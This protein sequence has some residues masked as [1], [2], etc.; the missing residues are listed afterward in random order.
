VAWCSE[1][2]TR[3]VAAFTIIEVAAAMAVV[4]IASGIAIAGMQEMIAAEKA[5]AE[6]VRLA[7]DIRRHRARAMQEG[8]HSLVR[9]E[10][11]RGG[12]VRLIYGAKR[13]GDVGG[14]TPCELMEAGQHDSEVA[15]HY[16]FIEAEME[17]YAVIGG[18]TD[19]GNA[20]AARQVCFTSKGEPRSS[21]LLTEKPVGIE[22]HR[23]GKTALHLEIDRLGAMVSPQLQSST[24]VA[25]TSN[26]PEDTMSTESAPIPPDTGDVAGPVFEVLPGVYVTGVAGGTASFG[27]VEYDPCYTDPCSCSDCTTDSS[28]TF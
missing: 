16:P 7:M 11:V 1:R 5:R 10:D 24:G 15:H 23:G 8:M 20:T 2:T 4:G 9:L 3:L 12:G 25:Q 6:A 14:N 28:T 26:H 27:E 17:S 18:N 21:D 19:T 13:F 22:A